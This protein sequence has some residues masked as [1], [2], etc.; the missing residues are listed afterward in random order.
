MPIVLSQAER[1]P[2]PLLDMAREL[3]ATIDA[4]LD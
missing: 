1:D 3:E 4:A 2:R